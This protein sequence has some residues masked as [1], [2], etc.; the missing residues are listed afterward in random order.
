MLCE[1]LQKL[2]YI[3]GWGFFLQLVFC[4]GEKRVLSFKRQ[5]KMKWGT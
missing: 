3:R 4:F 5:K 1:G 2:S